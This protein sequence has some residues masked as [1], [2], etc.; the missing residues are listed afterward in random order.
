M[1]SELRIHIYTNLVIP[2]KAG[3]HFIHEKT[4]CNFIITPLFTVSAE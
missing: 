4:Y 2:A 3:I 1:N